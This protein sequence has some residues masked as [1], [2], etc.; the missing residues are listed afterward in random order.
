MNTF[1]TPAIVVQGAAALLALHWT[2]PAAHARQAVAM[3]P[4][5][6]ITTPT[7]RQ[8]GGDTVV[9]V[10][11]WARLAWATPTGF[12]VS[13]DGSNCGLQCWTFSDGYVMDKWVNQVCES[14]GRVNV[15]PG[16]DP[17][18]VNGYLVQP[19]GP[20]LV[21]IV[22]DEIVY[23]KC[24]GATYRWR[25][26][27]FD[28]VVPNAPSGWVEFRT[29]EGTHVLEYGVA[30]QPL[31]LRA[32]ASTG[33]GITLGA[34]LCEPNAAWQVRD[35]AL[36]ADSITVR[37]ANPATGSQR[38]DLYARSGADWAL[39][40][41]FTST[42]LGGPIIGVG[43][44]RAVVWSTDFGR[45][46]AVLRIDVPNPFAETV[47]E[48]PAPSAG[49]QYSAIPFAYARR[50]SLLCSVTVPAGTAMFVGNRPEQALPCP[51]D[52]NA[53]RVV[54]GADLGIVLDQWGPAQPT[55]IAD[56]DRDGI[57]NGQDLG[58]LLT[59]WGACP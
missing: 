4:V 44:R 22:G 43:D 7:P 46:L 58:Q 51:G 17:W 56:I 15:G 2:V 20:R 28:I 41:T 53:D 47:Y 21:G 32:V 49:V 50:G 12:A 36:R 29:D 39:A 33:S 40:R 34:V 57:V 19:P 52:L 26:G 10:P 25:P 9:L 18:C 37:L 1:R 59:H 5:P 54:D 3:T 11:G 45:R 13:P 24:S 31:G 38:V 14:N 16:S 8:T 42:Q 27:G 55:T 30:G 23:R 48:L 35:Y 6:S